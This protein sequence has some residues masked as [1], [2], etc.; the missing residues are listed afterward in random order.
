MITS[1]DNFRKIMKDDMTL[2][3]EIY[4]A[5]IEAQ[6]I[7]ERKTNRNFELR[8]E[9]GEII[10][11]SEILKK[12]ANGR[13]YPSATPIQT[14]TFPSNGTSHGNAISGSTISAW[15]P[16]ET[17]VEYT[18]GYEVDDMPVEIVRAVAEIASVLVKSTIASEFTS[19]PVGATSIHVGDVSFTGKNL[20]TRAVVVPD[21]IE[22]LLYTWRR[23]SL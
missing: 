3:D 11:R 8:N 1:V 2:D 14:V 16:Y 10:I 18:G 17:R 23:P 20:G 5:L 13:V 19:A 21:H 12:Y 9:D 4:A 22:A 6:K 15:Y 7:V